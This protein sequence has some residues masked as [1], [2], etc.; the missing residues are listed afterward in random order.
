MPKRGTDH[1]W[2]LVKYKTD[3][4]IYARCSCKYHYPCSTNEM[5]EDGS[6]HQVPTIIYP[7]CPNCGARKKWYTNKI[8]NIDKY[9]FEDV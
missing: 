7:Y 8:K 1:T 2:Q 4:S 6:F 5:K 9:Y 3:S